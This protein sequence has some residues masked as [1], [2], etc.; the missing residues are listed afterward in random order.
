MITALLLV[1]A[2]EITALPLAGDCQDLQHTVDSAEGESTTVSFQGLELKPVTGDQEVS[3]SYAC[4][5][6]LKIAT[7]PGFRAGI[8]GIHV[9]GHAATSDASS[10]DLTVRGGAPGQPSHASVLKA[11]T[12]AGDFDLALGGGTLWF[13]CGEQL[14]EYNVSLDMSAFQ[15]AGAASSTQ[16]RIDTVSF[17]AVIYRRCS[18]PEQN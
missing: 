9:K 2:A 14:P 13:S 1:A 18:G 11:F 6:G 15:P 16:M 4:T 10:L 8:N 7:P 3:G 5:V 12:E 17:G